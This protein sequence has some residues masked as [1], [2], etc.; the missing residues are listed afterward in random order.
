M[1]EAKKA[2]ASSAGKTVKVLHT[3]IFRVNFCNVFEARTGDFEGSEPK[4]GLTAVFDP[5]KFSEKDKERWKAMQG[6]ANEVSVQRFGKPVKDLSANFKRPI[7]DG[8]EKEGL[9]GFGAGKK[10][11]NLTTKRKPGIIDGRTKERIVDDPDAFYSGCYA[12]A[13]IV[14]YGYDNKGK[15]IAFGLN[16]LQKVADGARLDGGGDPAKDF[17]EVELTAEDEA[18][19]EEQDGATSSEDDDSGF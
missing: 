9:D 13:T 12:R 8:A 19:L 16:N 6:L 15:G 5:S 7:R 14:C 4:Y 3:P 18:W 1:A 17:A 2:T 11:T 10:F